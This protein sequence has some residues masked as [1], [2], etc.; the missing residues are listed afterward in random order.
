MRLSQLL[1]REFQKTSNQFYLYSEYCTAYYK[2]VNL[3]Q[4]LYTQR[5]GLEDFLSFLSHDPRANGLD[6]FSYLIKPVQV[7]SF[8]SFHVAHLQVLPL[9]HAHAVQHGAKPPVPLRHRNH[10]QQDRRHRHHHQRDHERGRGG[11][12]AATGVS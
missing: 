3:L 10:Q 7:V 1:A 8:P 6:L 2:A 4:T 12:P 5:P 11:K 9:L